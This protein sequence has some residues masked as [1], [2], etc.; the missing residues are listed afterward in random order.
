MRMQPEK[1][2]PDPRTPSWDFT[3]T[4]P[5]PRT[6]GTARFLANPGFQALALT[7][8]DLQCPFE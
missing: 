8:K 7:I 6:M 3:C 4:I 1:R 2:G 5:N